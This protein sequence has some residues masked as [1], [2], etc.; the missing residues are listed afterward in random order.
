M[1]PFPLQVMEA[2]Q[3]NRLGPI[4]GILDVDPATQCLAAGQGGGGVDA[5]LSCAEIVE[6]TLAETKAA[7]SRLRALG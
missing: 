7:L 3:A 5:I 2:A 6:R 1:K 4:A